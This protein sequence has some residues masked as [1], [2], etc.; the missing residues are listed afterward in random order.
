MSQGPP[1]MFGLQFGAPSPP[2][3]VDEQSTTPLIPS[4]EFGEPMETNHPVPTATP[5]YTQAEN[6][7][8]TD[9]E[10]FARDLDSLS[11]VRKSP[12]EQRA[13]IFKLVDSYYHYAAKKVHAIR[14]SQGK[15]A[16]TGLSHSHYASSQDS[17]ELDDA[18]NSPG[19]PGSAESLKRWELEAQTWDLLRRL[20]PLRYSNKTSLKPTRHDVTRF[21]SSSELW[22]EFLQS[23]STAQERKAVLECLQASADESRTDIDELVRDYQ[24]RAERGDIIAYGWL[25]TRSAIKMQKNLHGWS[26]ALDPNAPDVVQKLR[27]GPNPLVT[28]L[29]PDVATRQNRKLLPQDEYFERAIW[30]GCYELLRRGRSIAEIRDWCV[31]RTEVWRAV[32]MSAMPLS[33]EESDIRFGC[34]PLSMLLWRRTCFALARQ[35][36]TDDFERAVYGILS[37]DIQSVE[38]I[39]EDWD[40]FVYA[41]Y[42]ALLRTQFDAYLMKRSPPDATAAITQ[43]FPAAFN[44]VQ[45]HGDAGSVGERLV[46]SLETNDKT[47]KEAKTP[48]KTLQAAILSDNLDQYTYE[49]GL[50]LSKLAN[51]EGVS[52]LI[53]RYNSDDQDIDDTKYVQPT[54]HSS[55]RV[56]VHVYLILSN[57]EQL[58]GGLHAELSERHKV[59]ENVLSAYVTTLRLTGLTDI[60]PLYCSHMQGDRAFFTLSRNVTGVT[61]QPEREI[62]LRLMEKLGMDI[63]EFVQFQPRSILQQHPLPAERPP[64]FGRF[65]M[66]SNEPP[67]LKY[68]RP[69][70]PDFL[71]EPPENLDDVDEHLIQSLEWFLLVDGL[72]YE[73]FR[74]GTAIYKR[75]LMQF[76]LHAARALADR[77]RCS[78][79]FKRKAGIIYSDDSDVSWFEEVRASAATGSLEDNGLS[80][81]EIAAAQNY[82]EMECLTRAL[83]L[84][85]TIASSQLLVQDPAERVGRD[86]WSHIGHELKTIKSLMQPILNNWLMESIEED[87]DFTYLRDA[88]LPETVIGYVSVLHFAGTA[89]TRD[90]LLECMELA[91][92]IAKKDADVQAVIMKA[93]RMKEL[94]E[95]FASCSKALAVSSNDKKGPSGMNSKRMMREH[96][97]T[98]ELWSVKK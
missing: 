97:W 70:K 31:E 1:N 12:A 58:E 17:M 85:E 4:I 65:T 69:L 91:S 64:P 34:D 89:L 27:N 32:S 82:F 93:G 19:F 84:M 3:D 25:H 22:E 50:A 78:E 45:F 10:E 90:N 79:I 9:A 77:V 53:P 7:F 6:E 47:S 55:L 63:A 5:F 67:S 87:E 13:E 15:G 75:F 71:G 40:D 54:D 96:G 29:D 23:D 98:R 72:W 92:V 41:H 95:G 57:L 59:Q 35:G 38:K 61:D 16:G 48:V 66:F 73:T 11:L 33:K 24:Q 62:L 43:S 60:M 37:G 14:K 94:V 51:K 39:C 83:D 74:Y 8:A 52:A 44:A 86:F 56:L 88:Y 26:G 18:E 30:V 49:L 20:L 80:P 2:L 81:E 28:Q 21:Q 42:N 36:G 46:K 76:N 68:G